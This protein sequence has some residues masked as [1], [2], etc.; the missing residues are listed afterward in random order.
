MRRRTPSVQLCEIA[1]LLRALA[2]RV[3]S[4]KATA[5][6]RIEMAPA[7]GEVWLVAAAVGGAR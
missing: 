5:N 2:E 1:A 6:L 4:G 3:E 7:G